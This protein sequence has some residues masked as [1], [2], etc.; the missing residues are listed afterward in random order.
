MDKQ[1]QTF[2]LPITVEQLPVLLDALLSYRTKQHYAWTRHV[3]QKAEE[4]GRKVALLD[5]L[6]EN[7]PKLDEKVPF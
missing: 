7:T 6:I 2:Y 3:G 1:A 4:L 5:Q